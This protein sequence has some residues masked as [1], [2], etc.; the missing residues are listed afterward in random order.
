MEPPT[1]PD[2]KLLRL[3]GKGSYGEVWI[4]RNIMGTFRAVKI[5]YKQQFEDERPYQREFEG[6]KRYEPISRSHEGLINV[7]HVG[8]NET[9]DCF[10]YVMELADEAN[11]DLLPS[12]GGLHHIGGDVDFETYK[13]KTLRSE[14]KGR[15]GL[16]FEECVS[17]SLSLCSGLAYLHNCG[18][19]HRDLKPSNIIFVNGRPKLADIGLVSAV[20][21]PGSIVGTEGYMAPEGSSSIQG[22][23][24]GL[25]KVLYEMATGKDRRD[26]PQMPAEWLTNPACA[27]LIEFNEVLIKACDT[28]SKRRYKTVEEMLG[29][30]ALLQA[31]KSIRRMRQLERRITRL[32]RAAIIG[33]TA[34]VFAT[35]AFFFAYNQV[36]RERENVRRLGIAEKKAVDELWK[37][38]FA[39]ARASILSSAP[40]RRYNA[41]AALES[42]AKIRP[43]LDLRNEALTALPMLDIRATPFWKDLPPIPLP[44]H[45][46]DP[47]LKIYVLE[48]RENNSLEVRRIPGHEL[49][50][51]LKYPPNHIAN[52]MLFSRS[53]DLFA[54]STFEGLVNIWET[55]DWRNVFTTNV[56]PN[57]LMALAFSPDGTVFAMPGPQ[58]D[59]LFFDVHS[60]RMLKS[61]EF[62]NSISQLS[63]NANGDKLGVQLGKE[64]K[65]LNWPGCE[66]RHSINFAARSRFDWHPKKD[67]IVVAGLHP[68][69]F[70]FDEGE[71]K[72]SSFKANDFGFS[73]ITIHPSGSFFGSKC[74]DGTTRFFEIDTGRELLST[75]SAYG[76]WFSRDGRRMWREK[77]T[78]G[79]GIWEVSDPSCYFTLRL[80]AGGEFKELQLS[81]D[82]TLLAGTSG[83][84]ISVFNLQTRNLLSVATSNEAYS[85]AFSPCGKWL[86]GS[87]KGSRNLLKCSLSK[88]NEQW[89]VGIAEKLTAPPANQAYR[90]SLSS[91]K[92]RAALARM[93]M[94]QIF[95]LDN[96]KAVVS[97]SNLWSGLSMGWH[98]EGNLLAV[99]T[100]RSSGTTVW[101]CNTG[102]LKTNL[103]AGNA[104]VQFSPDGKWLAVGSGNSYQL[105]ET[106]RWKP[107]AKFLR[108]T[109]SD[110]PGPLAFS[111]M[112]NFLWIAKNHQ[113]VKLLKIPRLE[114]VASLSIPKGD[115]ITWI[116]ASSDDQYLVVGTSGDTIH[117]WN[118]K[119]MRSDLARLG[120]D[121]EN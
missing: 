38:Q 119:M 96:P 54:F 107:G 94:V 108:D 44:K 56:P 16:S 35:A 106:G 39:Q 8:Q 93:S 17:I 47:D 80:P 89:F 36:Q 121:W 24:F 103:G 73:H 95:P 28:D 50:T 12:L 53:G 60:G 22:D 68:N 87:A 49:V 14:I 5:V 62:T 69:V 84:G 59:V 118:L 34:L 51:N 64:L 29:D 102:V 83:A 65:V 4:A 117:V 9:G 67:Q 92:K 1:I 101:D 99:G 27:S 77:D 18:L 104:H 105:Y 48:D 7:L 15:A 91:D 11:R 120:L 111:H 63:F 46:L 10:Y 116:T 32:T 86:Y 61:I 41:L 109:V 114:E 42:A 85:V 21:D 25:G 72:L 81:A 100:W 98:P 6:I 37:A 40:S 43:S 55:K 75:E 78:I 82:N 58:S 112:G 52:G 71:G 30:I 79:F 70:L 88:S 115:R 2:H 45:I 57:K 110:Y 74:L 31:G 76:I 33:S 97:I 3:I 90:F 19:L 23:I 26:F 66:V 13:P 113:Q 20:S